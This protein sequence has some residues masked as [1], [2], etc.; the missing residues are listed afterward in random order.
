MAKHFSDENT[1]EPQSPRRVQV[2]EEDL[3]TVAEPETEFA[4]GESEIA[5]GEPA[6]SDEDPYVAYG[7]ETEDLEEGR[8]CSAL[9]VDSVLLLR[10]PPDASF[11]HSHDR[12]HGRQRVLH[13]R[14]RAQER[15]LRDRLL[16][17][18]DELHVLRERDSLRQ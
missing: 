2:I 6:Y 12:A 8:R 10:G 14:R 11:R 7:E 15:F 13:E 17:P 16:H 18:R 5:D 1:R 4:V 9:A 3:E